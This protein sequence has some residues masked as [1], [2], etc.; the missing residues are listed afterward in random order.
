MSIAFV[1]GILLSAAVHTAPQ[2]VNLAA[3]GGWDIV[4]AADATP[5]EAYA[6]QEFQGLFEQ[7]AGM[8]LPIAT[9]AASPDRHIFVGPG[10]AMLGNVAG[11]RVEDFGDEDF[12]IVI[13]DNAIVIAG[14]RPR[15][16]LYGTYTFLED[17]AGVRFLTQ[18]HTHVPRIGEWRVVGPVDRFVHPP[19]AFRWSFYAETNRYPA[20]AARNRTNTVAT[21]ARLGGKTGLQNINHTFVSLL[22]S[23]EFGKEHP[24]YYALVDGKRL[25]DV[26]ND[27]VATQLCL[28]NPDVLRIVTQRVLE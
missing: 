26:S 11:F 15:G 7:S 1:A 14:G 5:S 3:L 23:K 4:V 27:G 8:K 20:F 24:E 2:G 17:Y 22:P 21:E 19:L 6:A 16:T 18:D 10:A 25:A 13:R 12:R 9:V 28:T